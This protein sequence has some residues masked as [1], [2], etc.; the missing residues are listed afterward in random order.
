[1]KVNLQSILIKLWFSWVGPNSAFQVWLSFE[2]VDY[3]VCVYSFI[4]ELIASD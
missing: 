3:L 1:M 2:E 4:Q